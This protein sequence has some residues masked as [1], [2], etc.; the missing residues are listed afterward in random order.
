ML[1]I[2]GIIVVAV[3]V[4][5]IVKMIFY[6]VFPEH[7]LKVAEKRYQENP[8]P[9]NERLLWDARSRVNKTRK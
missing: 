3:V 4:W 9:V 2:I 6:R 7:G 5:A 8:D 1:Q